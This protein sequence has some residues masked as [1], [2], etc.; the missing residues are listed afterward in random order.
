M[1]LAIL[2]AEHWHVPLYLTGFAKAGARVVAYTADDALPRLARL[3][4]DARRHGDDAGLVGEGGF[5][6]LFV[7]GRHD[8]MLGRCDLAV[9][10][11]IPFSVEKPVSLDAAALAALRDRAAR[12]GVFAS[13][14]L[15]YRCSGIAKAFLA[16]DGDPLHLSIRN[17]GGPIA[18]YRAGGNAWMEERRA[19]FGGAM[20]NL[21][22]HFIDLACR[23]GGLPEGVAGIRARRTPGIGVDEYAALTLAFPSGFVAQ[24]E[25]TYTFPSVADV[26]R[27]FTISLATSKGYWTAAEDRLTVFRPGAAPRSS[28]LGLAVEPFFEAYIVETL[29][30]IADG[31]APLSGLS[32]LERIAAILAEWDRVAAWAGPPSSE[33]RRRA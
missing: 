8:R 17:I 14:A 31:R 29:A 11:G 26:P 16:A 20:I 4:P 24:V 33:K 25:C 7:F 19:A 12:Q 2:G 22:P 9:G 5:D 27:D 3:F 13:V 21:G 32:E 15:P 18:R 23:I 6:A 10:A 1:H 28:S 30:R